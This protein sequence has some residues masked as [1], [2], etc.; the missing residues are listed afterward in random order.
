MDTRK[1]RATFDEWMEQIRRTLSGATIHIYPPAAPT[2]VYIADIHCNNVEVCA[3]FHMSFG[4]GLSKMGRIP[5]FSSKPD[6]V[7]KSADEATQALKK[8]LNLS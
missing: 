4:Y 1:A 5:S 3:Q 2:G 7:Y 8:L 6:S